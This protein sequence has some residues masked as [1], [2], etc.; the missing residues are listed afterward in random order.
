MKLPI[1]VVSL[2]TLTGMLF[3]AGCQNGS[4]G[5]SSK[6]K[7]D[8]DLSGPTIYELAF[9]TACDSLAST[10]ANLYVQL[11]GQ[12]GNSPESKMAYPNET[13]EKFTS[14]SRD[15]FKLPVDEHLGELDSMRVWHDNSGEDPSWKVEIISI[16][17]TKSGK[18]TD[19][20]CGKWFATNLDDGKLSRMFYT[21][22][23]CK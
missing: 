22:R 7:T 20:P 2:L 4:S 11:Y 17:D 12:N 6:K 19:W 21:F 10:K 8:K 15:V 9:R 23:E 13:Q 3:F 1:L 18:R 14:C 16:V 5:G